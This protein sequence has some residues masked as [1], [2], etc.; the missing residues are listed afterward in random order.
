MTE[1]EAGKLVFGDK[2]K[3]QWSKSYPVEEGRIIDTKKYGN[4]T[5]ARV[6]T[7]RTYGA[8]GAKQILELV[9]SMGDLEVYKTALC[10]IAEIL[11]KLKVE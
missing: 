10:S 8:Y 1:A 5:V 4:V 2:V 11:K 6:Y 3:V 7:G 9:E